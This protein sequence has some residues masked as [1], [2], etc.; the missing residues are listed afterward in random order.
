MGTAFSIMRR[1]GY[2]EVHQ[3]LQRGAGC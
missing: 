1:E 3:C 2:C